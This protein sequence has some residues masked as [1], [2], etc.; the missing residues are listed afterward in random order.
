MARTSQKD[1]G[2]RF[3]LIV[4]AEKEGGEPGPLSVDVPGR[5]KALAVFSSEEEALLFL[6]SAALGEC[7]RIGRV[8]AGELAS[9]LLSD[10]VGGASHVLLDP[11]S[12]VDAT[13]TVGLVGM[14]RERFLVDLLGSEAQ[15]RD[16]APCC[17]PTR[18]T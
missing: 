18:A 2:P 15:G 6:R 13:V 14:G 3:W 16:E 12:E 11:M 9:M 4:G 17:V 7:W 1:W 10:T 8:G 5:G